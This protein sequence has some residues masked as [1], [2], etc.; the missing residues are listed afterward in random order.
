MNGRIAQYVN[1][2]SNFKNFQ[3][4]SWLGHPCHSWRYALQILLRQNRPSMECN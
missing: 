3:L 2:V 1:V 4:L